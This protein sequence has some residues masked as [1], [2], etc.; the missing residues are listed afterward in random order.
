MSTAIGSV[1]NTMSYFCA[2]NRNLKK[3]QNQQNYNMAN[4]VDISVLLSYSPSDLIYFSFIYLLFL[5]DKTKIFLNLQRP[6]TTHESNA[7]II[8]SNTTDT[9]QCQAFY[10][11]IFLQYRPI[12]TGLA[13][14]LS[15]TQTDTN[16][17]LLSRPNS[18]IEFPLQMST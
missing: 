3:L 6:N 11:R 18:S 17:V 13:A 16:A 8:W 15:C 7:N 10:A 12:N 2:M 14:L 1:L 4:K 5:K 9:M